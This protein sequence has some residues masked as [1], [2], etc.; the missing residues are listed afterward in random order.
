VNLLGI[1]FKDIEVVSVL[2]QLVDTIKR[3]SALVMDFIQCGGIDLFDKITRTHAKDE[4]LT[5]TI[6][7][8]VKAILGKH[9]MCRKSHMMID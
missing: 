7:K 2:V 9:C 4:Y 3:E 6:P 8:L 5:L 1:S